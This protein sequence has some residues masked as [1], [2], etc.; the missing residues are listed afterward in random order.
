MYIVDNCDISVHTFS[1]SSPYYNIENKENKKYSICNYSMHCS[2]NN[3]FKIPKEL[4]TCN[5]EDYDR[6]KRRTFVNSK[7]IITRFINAI[8][9]ELKRC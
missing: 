1:D 5:Y 4:V 6:D 9:R 2:N 3:L 8:M 7:P